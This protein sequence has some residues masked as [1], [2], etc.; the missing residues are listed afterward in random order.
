VKS[1][2]RCNCAAWS[3]FVTYGK[4]KTAQIHGASVAL[5]LPELLNVVTV[6]C[7]L[8]CTGG[9]E[10]VAVG[11]PEFCPGS[12]RI[13]ASGG[14]YVIN[15]CGVKD[16]VER[17]GKSGWLR[18]LQDERVFTEIKGGKMSSS[19]TPL[20]QEDP[21]GFGTIRVKDVFY[22]YYQEIASGESYKGI[23]VCWRKVD[24]DMLINETIRRLD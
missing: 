13:I 4:T 17:Y 8:G 10:P 7:V 9:K 15:V 24:R 21:E 19:R 16:Y 6:V 2:W 3:A 18:G 12:W 20:R 5:S 1:L 11:V 14:F 22:D 23:D